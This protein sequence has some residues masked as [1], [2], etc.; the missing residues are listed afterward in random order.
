[1]TYEPPE[2][3]KDVWKLQPLPEGMAAD[4]KHA[5]KQVRAQARRA[6]QEQLLAAL[7]KAHPGLVNGQDAVPVLTLK[8]VDALLRAGT[9][10][11][12]AIAFKQ[13]YNFGARGLAE[14][15][16]RGLWDLEVPTLAREL[17][18]PRTNLDPGDWLSLPALAKIRSALLGAVTD[19]HFY[20][21]ADNPYVA[22]ARTNIPWQSRRIN[23]AAMVAGATMV[24]AIVNGALVAGPHLIDA[25]VRAVV[26]GPIVD[27]GM[28]WV[29]LIITRP[30]RKSPD[31]T[32]A[33]LLRR[34]FPDP[35]TSL[36]MLRFQAIADPAD[37]A[38]LPTA[39]K[40]LE[41][42]L[43]GLD[44]E[45]EKKPTLSALQRI[46]IQHHT[47]QLPSVILDYARDLNTARSLP[48][49]AWI[50]LRHD[51]LCA[52]N[53]PMA[54]GDEPLLEKIDTPALPPG[55]VKEQ[56]RQYIQLLHAIDRINKKGRLV[57]K[58]FHELAQ[59]RASGSLCPLLTLITHWCEY[60]MSPPAG[61]RKPIRK[62]SLTTYLSGYGQRLMTYGYDF[63]VR[64]ADA[65]EYITLYEDIGK[66]ITEPR[67]KA[68]VRSGL[69]DFH[70]YLVKAQ[71][72]PPVEIDIDA[73]GLSVDNNLVT[74]KEYEWAR[75]ALRTRR[76]VAG[77]HKDAQEL[78][79]IL[80]F[81]AG[82]R[83]SEV[84]YLRLRDLQI[85]R[86]KDR[87]GRPRIT[88][89]ELF[90]EPHRGRQLKSASGRRRLPLHLL[91]SESELQRLVEFFDAQCTLHRWPAHN[92]EA[93]LFSDLGE[94]RLPLD[95]EHTFDPITFALQTATGDETTRFQ[96]LRHSFG[97]RLFTHLL[98]A[99]HPEIITA[100]WLGLDPAVQVGDHALAE[101]YW[102]TFV[103]TEVRAPSRKGLFAL[104]A[105]MGH[106]SPAT[107]LRSY[108]HVLDLALGASLERIAPRLTIEQQA[109]LLGVS[110]DH[111]RSSRKRAQPSMTGDEL[112]HAARWAALRAQARFGERIPDDMPAQRPDRLP[113]MPTRARPSLGEVYY[114]LSRAERYHAQ[115]GGYLMA[116]ARR[117]ASI[118]R[119]SPSEV[120]GWIKKAR[121]LA[122]V[123]GPRKA[124][125]NVRARL[126]R[127][128]PDYPRDR[129]HA[130]WTPAPPHTRALMNEAARLYSTLIILFEDPEKRTLIRD[131]MWRV[132]HDGAT[133]E[134]H[135]YTTDES[136]AK[137]LIEFTNTI[138]IAKHRIEVEVTEGRN[139][140]KPAG[141]VQWKQYFGVEK[142]KVKNAAPR[143]TAEEHAG[144]VDSPKP[145]RSAPGGVRI[146]VLKPDDYPLIE[147]ARAP[148]YAIQGI[149]YAVFMAAVVY[150]LS[151]PTASS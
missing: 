102:E 83:R 35:L 140:L 1:M 30:Y 64:E 149:R 37:G 135:F 66:S 10:G 80:G 85:L 124:R 25:F 47:Q 141:A 42:I 74:R 84:K 77:R 119:R 32:D 63:S 5:A 20:A 81:R 112:V 134:S 68:R 12:A 49:S 72:A 55:N 126:H 82:L 18:P 73:Q 139:G 130:G 38:N 95:D 120:V 9:K 137:A 92:T 132:L 127:D 44:L 107:A 62:R 36:L 109:I 39:T 91:L 116:A 104:A 11:L 14:G 75:K 48:V 86:T 146:K 93:L 28:L 45:L 59:L 101:Q 78:I 94:P 69:R 43:A 65:E 57:R 60:R 100:K 108:L 89:V 15:L 79:L 34:Y 117:V 103:G 90:I 125:R 41:Y 131:G 114:A 13:T 129:A 67:L 3:L 115:H 106:R 51:R 19:P 150:G 71:V 144:T 76:G 8:E 142:V 21:L 88:E 147:T 133:I 7:E 17:R 33:H 105:A 87:R 56:R 54:T 61:G 99:R 70:D 40:L 2:N 123:E 23:P 46:A 148:R 52:P 27:R 16:Q 145:K 98:M 136:E 31:R 122:E 29:D 113:P 111:W 128:N 6:N 4:P 96:H 58:D 138:G 50:R 97:N 143:A 24:S 118:L 110:F 22:R 121:H 151:E 26:S 53:Q